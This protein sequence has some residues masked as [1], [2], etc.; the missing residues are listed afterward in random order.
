[1][2]TDRGYGDAIACRRTAGRNDGAQGARPIEECDGAGGYASAGA[3]RRDGCREENGLAIHERCPRRGEGQRCGSLQVGEREGDRIGNA[4]DGRGGVI[5]RGTGG[6]IG[7][8]DNGAVS[9][10][11]GGGGEAGG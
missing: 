9:N 10:R 3:R 4:T 1:M 2:R 5:G 7:G 8:G 11:R 6:A